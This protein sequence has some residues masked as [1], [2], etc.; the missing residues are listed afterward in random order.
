M[1]IS[2]LCIQYHSNAQVWNRSTGSYTPEFKD[3]SLQYTIAG[4][5]FDLSTIILQMKSHTVVSVGLPEDKL[6]TSCRR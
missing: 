3:K 1:I 2:T 4:G 6:T 5:A